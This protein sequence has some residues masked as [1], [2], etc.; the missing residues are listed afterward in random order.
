MKK[1]MMMIALVGV[2]S[3]ATAQDGKEA[4]KKETA[5]SCCS[6]DAKSTSSVDK[7]ACCQKPAAG[8]KKACCKDGDKA[9]ASA[10]KTK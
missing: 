7:K 6:K 3:F 2:V 8:E 9:K 5:K 10:T 1:L 4:T